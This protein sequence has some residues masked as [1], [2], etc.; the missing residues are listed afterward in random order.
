MRPRCFIYLL[1]LIPPASECEPESCG[2]ILPA[3]QSRRPGLQ[4]VAETKSKWALSLH[5]LLFFGGEESGFAGKRHLLGGPAGMR[6]FGGL[7]T[8]TAV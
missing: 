8:S 3:D 4:V 2:W 6:R 1:Q 5:F 7:K